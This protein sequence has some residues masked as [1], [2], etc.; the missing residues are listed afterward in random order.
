MPT[1]LRIPPW[2]AEEG[3]RLRHR[4]TQEQ[5]PASA[6]ARPHLRQGRG[7]PPL[8]C[9]TRP[10]AKTVAGGSAVPKENPEAAS[11]VHPAGADA[12]AEGVPEPR[13]PADAQ[14]DRVRRAEVL[15]PEEPAAE[16]TA[17]LRG[18]AGCDEPHLA[19]S[20]SIQTGG[21][22]GTRG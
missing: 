18:P 15:A 9:G 21:Y 2:G 6:S 5:Q 4:F 17:R 12:L 11:A 1:A 10:S 13:H 22:S 19:L 3:T 7:R 8:P 20:A 16:A 14:R